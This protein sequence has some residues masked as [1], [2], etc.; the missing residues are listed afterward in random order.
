MDVLLLLYMNISFPLLQIL[1]SPN[2]PIGLPFLAL[3]FFFI[4]IHLVVLY[5]LPLLDMHLDLL[6]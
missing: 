3:Y 4:Y 6:C 2:I 1:A 5:T